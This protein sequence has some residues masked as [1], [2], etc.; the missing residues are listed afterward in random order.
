MLF[1]LASLISL[2]ILELSAR[3]LW[4]ASYNHWLEGQLHGYDRVDYENEIVVLNPNVTLTYG[5]L[6]EELNEADKPLGVQRLEA[7]GQEFDFEPDDLVFQINQYGFKG[8]DIRKRKAPGTLRIMTIGDSVTFGL[9]VDVLSY[10][11]RMERAL[12]QALNQDNAPEIIGVE[13]VNAGVKGYNLQRVLKR[14]DYFL[15]FEPDVTTIFLGWNQ[16]IARADPSKNDYLY[17]ELASYRFFYHFLT[18][19]TD[20]LQDRCTIFANNFYDKEDQ[21]IETL[22]QTSFYWDFRDWSTLIKTIRQRSPKTKIVV[23][24]LPGLFIEDIDPDPAALSLGY[25]VAFSHNLYAWAVLT[26]IYNEK[27]IEFADEQN[28]AVIDLAQWSKSAFIPRSRYFTDPVHLT[29]EGHELI[30]RFMAQEFVER[31]YLS[32]ESSKPYRSEVLSNDYFTNGRE[33]ESPPPK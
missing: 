23:L 6:L 17:R 1:I 26:E 13:V 19:Q 10:P 21:L 7:L 29:P 3:I 30:G 25:S 27:L 33:E 28:L 22:R 4:K 14:I 12:N 24:T 2:V 9:T 5:N 18:N 16:T 15:E 32:L 20:V 31:G 11:R 8:P